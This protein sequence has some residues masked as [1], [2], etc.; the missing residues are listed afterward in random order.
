LGWGVGEGAGP[1]EEE[2]GAFIASIFLSLATLPSPV[3][4]MP[5][6]FGLAVLVIGP[7]GL[8]LSLSTL[9]P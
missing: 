2:T 1:A 7:Y 9:L 5:G 8:S 6:L 3:S 4:A